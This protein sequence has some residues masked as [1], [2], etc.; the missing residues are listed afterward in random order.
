MDSFNKI[1]KIRRR[2][3]QCY[4]AART[5]GNC[6]DMLRRIRSDGDHNSVMLGL[7][8]VGLIQERC[9]D[10][11]QAPHRFQNVLLIRCCFASD[12]HPN[13]TIRL[14]ADNFDRQ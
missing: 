2:R 10:A 5:Y 3:G 6:M 13:V 8:D 14:R 1:H 12:N 9:G 11:H 4:E 7:S